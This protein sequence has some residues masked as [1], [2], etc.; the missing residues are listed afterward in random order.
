MDQHFTAIIGVVGTLLGVV[1]G[2]LLN[3][4][5][6]IGRVKFYTNN[7]EYGYGGYSDG[8]GGYIPYESFTNETKSVTVMIDID[9]INTS[10]YSKKILRDINFLTID[11]GFEKNHNIKDLSTGRKL[12]SSWKTDDLKSINLLPKEIKTIN[13]RVLFNEDLEKVLN[14]KWYIEYKTPNNRIRKI[15]IERTD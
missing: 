10:E 3:R 11:K 13:I 7:I 12:H 1:L 2:A 15:R 5:S 14:S 6:R 4:I 9:I 8:T